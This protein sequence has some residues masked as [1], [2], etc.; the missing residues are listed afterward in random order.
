MGYLDTDQ[1]WNIIDKIVEIGEARGRTPAQVALRWVMQKPG[2]TAPIIGAKRMAH[3]E[4]NLQA[5]TFELSDEEMAV[6]GHGW[7]VVAARARARGC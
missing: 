6:R 2:V 3:L 4:D 1:N 5:A 7:F